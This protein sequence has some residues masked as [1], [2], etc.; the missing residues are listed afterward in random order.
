MKR[1]KSVNNNINVCF[2][3]NIAPLYRKAIFNV[4]DSNTEINFS[5]KAGNLSYDIDAL[6]NLEELEGYKA[7]LGNC[8][9]KKKL[10]WQ[11]GALKSLWQNYDAFILTG[12]PGIRSNWILLIL[13]PLFGKKVYLWSHGLYGKESKFQKFKNLL[14]MRLSSGLFLYG[15]YGRQLLLKEGFSKSQL[16]VVY[17]SLNYELHSSLRGKFIGGTFMR[18]YFGNDYPVIIF[19]GR[20]T[21]QKSLAT[22]IEAVGILKVS[23][24][25]VNLLFVGSGEAEMELQNRAKSADIEDRVWFYGECYDEE[26]IANLFQNSTLCVSP[27]NVGLTAIHS[28]SYGVPVITHNR[29]KYQMP[30]YEAIKSNVTGDLVKWGDSISFVEAIEKWVKRLSDPNKRENTRLECYKII[31]EYYT[32]YLQ[33]RVFVERIKRDLNSK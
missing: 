12:N 23:N 11:R 22:L 21:P 24:V 1:V 5:F 19:L 13:A 4:L 30:E 2:I 29:L 15:K 20:L 7:T 28:L 26:M 17:N 10:I 31:D 9:S 33:E 14:F 6:L 18:N 3:L 16:S 25:D 8:Y 27:G 32:P